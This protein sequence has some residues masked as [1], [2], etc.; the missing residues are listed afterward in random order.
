MLIAPSPTPLPGLPRRWSPEVQ[1]LK[2]AC[3]QQ[4]AMLTP[5]DEGRAGVRKNRYFDWTLSP[6]VCAELCR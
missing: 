4:L 2:E 5:R 3:A 1:A 6:A